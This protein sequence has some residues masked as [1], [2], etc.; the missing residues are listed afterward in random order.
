VARRDLSA[1]RQH[2]RRARPRAARRR[3]ADGGAAALGARAASIPFDEPDLAKATLVGV[4]HGDDRGEYLLLIEPKAIPTTQISGPLKVRLNAL[5][6][7]RAAAGRRG[8]RSALGC[9]AGG[10]GRCTDAPQLEGKAAPAGFSE[11]AGS[12]KEPKLTLGQILGGDEFLFLV[13]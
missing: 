2:H 5:R 7:A 12:A 3:C 11:P 9:A 13:P 6:A 10:R 1:G 4:A 8:W